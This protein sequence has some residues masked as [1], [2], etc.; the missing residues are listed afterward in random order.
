MLFTRRENNFTVVFNKRT[1]DK[2][3]V[4]ENLRNGKTHYT[5]E[6][7]KMLSM[8]R[9]VETSLYYHHSIFPD[10]FSVLSHLFTALGNG[11]E[12]VDGYLISDYPHP[13]EDL[14]GERCF[15]EYTEFE[16]VFF[17]VTPTERDKVS[18]LSEAGS[19]RSRYLILLP[20]TV[21][22]Y[23]WSNNPEFQPFRKFVGCKNPGFQE[24]VEYFIGVVRTLND[25]RI[26]QI[27]LAGMRNYWDTFIM[28]NPEYVQEETE[29]WLKDVN[30][31][32]KNIHIVEEV[33]L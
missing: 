14:D 6:E 5:K 13:D 2:F 17:G 24:E 3:R 30:D 22:L 9:W 1:G 16:K 19:W 18:Y 7:S 12:L 20:K 4:G 25:L 31:W 26:K 8:R 28:I 27:Y 23:P 15:Q 32:I 21:N 11:I 29:R 10:R 33:L